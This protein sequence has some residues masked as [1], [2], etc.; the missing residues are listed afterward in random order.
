MDSYK[1]DEVSG[2]RELDSDEM[3]EELMDE[4]NLV[5]PGWKISDEAYPDTNAKAQQRA[6]WAKRESVIVKPPAEESEETKN[7]SDGAYDSDS[8]AKD[9]GQLSQ[10]ERKSYEALKSKVT[11]QHFYGSDEEAYIDDQDG[12]EVYADDFRDDFSL[13]DTGA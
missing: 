12:E 4:H 7:Q 1:H 13:S 11:E 10:E 8:D 3:D 2:Q 6:G 9:A 5:Q